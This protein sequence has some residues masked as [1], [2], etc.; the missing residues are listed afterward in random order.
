MRNILF[1]AL[2][3]VASCA[4]AGPI[5][6]D[7]GH[8]LLFEPLSLQ[9]NSGVDQGQVFTVG[10]AGKLARVDVA[11]AQRTGVTEPLT[12]NVVRVVGDKPDFST[13]GVVATRSIKQSTVPLFSHSS[14]GSFTHSINLASS[15]IPVLVGDKLAIVLKTEQDPI[16]SYIWFGNDGGGAYGHMNPTNTTINQSFTTN[17]RT[18]VETV[19]E[20]SAAMVASLA[21]AGLGFL[22]RA[23]PSLPTRL[24]GG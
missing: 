23:L 21:L 1:I 7:Q 12:L 19:P 20:P 11:I 5:I 17:F 15:N 4:S 9:I 3:A 8:Q 2:V 14:L 24:A 6:Q 10:L 16:A 18:F 13:A 22:S